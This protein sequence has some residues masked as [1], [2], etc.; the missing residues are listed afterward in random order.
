MNHL[1]VDE[2]N[3]VSAI[4]QTQ[5]VQEGQVVLIRGDGALC[6]L[7]QFVIIDQ[8][9]V[10]AFQDE[11]GGQPIETLGLVINVLLIAQVRHGQVV[12]EVSAADIEDTFTP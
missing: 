7:P 8:L 11:L 6:F 2:G 1:V 12:N 10:L 5:G 4:P 3:A 9:I